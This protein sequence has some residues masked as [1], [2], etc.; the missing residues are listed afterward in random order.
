MSAP[1]D[2]PDYTV[3][4]YTP[5]DRPQVLG[6][7][8]RSLGPGPAGERSSEFFAWKH[9][10][11]PFGPSF[12]LVADA[13]GELIGFRAFMRW[14]FAAGERTA[15]AVRA[16]DTATDPAH[17]RKGVFRR[18]TEAARDEVAGQAALVFNTPNDQS[19]PGYLRMGWEHVG[20][21]PVAI[22]PARPVRVARHARQ[23]AGAPGEAGGPASDLP[24]AGD[25]LADDAAL[26]PLLDA[27]PRDG[28]LHTVRTPGYLR[29]RY[30]DAPG[31]D[32]RAVALPDGGGGLAGLAIGR[33]RQRG[34]LAELS[35][36]EALVRPGDRRAARRLLARVARAG[37][38]Y[39]VGSFDADATLRP[40]RR[41]AGYL[42]APGQG[43]TLVANP[44]QAVSPDPCD[45]RSWRLTLGDL[46][47]F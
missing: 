10:R 47:V 33:L 34:P 17:Q 39:A 12:A 21:P 42:P 26:R 22:R 36:A 14:Q 37:G 18:L 3:R 31:L 30:A 32:Y 11:N 43:P 7:L 2:G 35:L 4:A 38:D 9:E 6:L 5:A 28:R 8:A 27:Q 20:R 1:D 41:R 15:T 40:A 24:P 44:L 25:V 46:E 13:G 45:L 29:W 23:A 19:L 16:V